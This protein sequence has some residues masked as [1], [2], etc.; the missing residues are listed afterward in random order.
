VRLCCAYLVNVN[1]KNSWSAELLES[2]E[3]SM[4]VRET[5]APSGIVELGNAKNHEL[6]ELAGRLEAHARD[7]WLKRS[8]PH[9]R[10]DLLIAARD[11]RHPSSG[12]CRQGLDH[13]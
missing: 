8:R 1:E 11:L 13:D 12:G 3:D 5:P 6:R 4:A 2:P 9:L 10:S 7:K